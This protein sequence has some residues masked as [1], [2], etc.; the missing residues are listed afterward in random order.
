[1]KWSRAHET[2]LKAM[3]WKIEIEIAWSLA[4]KFKD[5]HDL[6]L[7]PD[8]ISLPSQLCGTFYTI[9]Y[10]KS[11]VVMSWSPGFVLDPAL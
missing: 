10:D 3:P 8:A 11:R 7:N 5:V 4:F 6:A 1:M 9:S 2:H